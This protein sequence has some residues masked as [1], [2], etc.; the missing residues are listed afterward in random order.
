MAGGAQFVDRNGKLNEAAVLVLS[1]ICRVQENLLTT[2]L[3]LPSSRNWLNA[4]FFSPNEGGGAMVIATRIYFTANWFRNDNLP[5]SYGRKDSVCTLRWIL[6]MAHEVRHLPQA[7]I[8]G[9]RIWNIMAYVLW[10]GLN[11]AWHAVTRKLP[12]VEHMPL[13]IDADLG[14][15][16]L[17]SILTEADTPPEEHVL[18]TAIHRNDVDSAREWIDENKA[19]IEFCQNKAGKW[20]EHR[21]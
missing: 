1:V 3:V 7:A 5:T 4:P 21:H 2:A 20:P 18:I 14:R 13:E 10:F 11:Y 6:L 17:R 9:Y 8:V 12:Y 15:K 16:T 19:L